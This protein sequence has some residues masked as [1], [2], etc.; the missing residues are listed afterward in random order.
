MKKKAKSWMSISLN[1]LSSA[2]KRP[3]LA[4]LSD[5]ILPPSD[6]GCRFDSHNPV[7]YECRAV[8]YVFRHVEQDVSLFDAGNV[9]VC[10]PFLTLHDKS[11]NPLS[12]K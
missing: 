1:V 12:T 2:I 5:V 10:K 9:D 3:S 6:F 4:I 11:V 7:W 8:R